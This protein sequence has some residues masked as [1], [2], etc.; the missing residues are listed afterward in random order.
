[1]FKVEPPVLTLKRKTFPVAVHYEP[2]RIKDYVRAAAEKAMHIHLNSKAGNI[3]IFLS[4]QA[5]IR[6]CMKLIQ[7]ML[8]NEGSKQ[9]LD[10]IE[11]IS[12]QNDC[13][14]MIETIAI[15]Q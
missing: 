1:M 2:S 14:D 5:E 11:E 13:D 12:E 15:Q 8:S 4:G 10:D 6:E 3:L 9:K 7:N